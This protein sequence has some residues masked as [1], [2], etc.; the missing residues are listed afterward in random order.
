VL[1]EIRNLVT[2]QASI[3][4]S[5]SAN[6]VSRLL[7]ECGGGKTLSRRF[8]RESECRQPTIQLGS[9]V[10]LDH[11]RYGARLAPEGS[12]LVT[13]P[14]QRIMRGFGLLADVPEAKQFGTYLL[15]ASMRQGGG[16]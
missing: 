4:L 11:R 10:F 15:D 7:N 2:H 14:N 12:H 6:I 9:T 5:T 1:L 3:R 8:R 13:F 16:C